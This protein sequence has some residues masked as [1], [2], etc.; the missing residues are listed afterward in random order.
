MICLG[1]K[2]LET[3]TWAA[4]AEKKCFYLVSELA[5]ILWPCLALGLKLDVS[6]PEDC[7][8]QGVL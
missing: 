4:S 2:C 6:A 5:A 7:V 8:V 1:L 3:V